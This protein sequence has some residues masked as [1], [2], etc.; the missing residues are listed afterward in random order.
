M[1]EELI[2]VLYIDD[3]SA[4][5]VSFKANFRFDFTVLLANSGQ[6]A[7]DLLEKEQVHIIIADQR[8]PGMTGIELFERVAQKHPDPV[9]ILLTGYTDVT[10]IIDSINKGNIYRYIQKPWNDHEIRIA[11]KNAYEIYSTKLNLYLKN[12]E[13]HKI[14]EELN[15]F[16]YSASHDLKAP[17]LSIKGLLNVARI[18][19]IDRNPDKY[20]S[21]ISNSINQLEIFIENIISYYK[22][23]RIPSS[24]ATIDFEKIVRETI[25][26]YNNYY[27]ATSIDFQCEINEKE[28]FVT[29]EFRIRVII[30]NLLSNAIKYQKH[31]ETHKLIRISILVENA[32][33]RIEIEDNGIGIDQQDLDDIYKMFYRATT[34]NSGSGI[35]LYIVQEAVQK[36]NGKI[37][38]FSEKDQGSKFIVQIPCVEP[39]L[40]SQIS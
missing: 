12:K 1:E 5:L 30:N 2:K 4:N 14:N 26:S 23:V 37:H 10:T 32:T 21:M 33:A 40:I 28:A 18:E 24:Y 25:K 13:L 35:G 36:I 38:V 11:I 27:N 39:A 19:G 22:N 34:Q 6:E 17:I 20:F 7:L 31:N 15:R 29:D 8:M 16:I 9:R 3:E